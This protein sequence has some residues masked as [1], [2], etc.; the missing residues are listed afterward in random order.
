MTHSNEC[1]IWE[2]HPAGDDGW[3]DC[4]C[5]V[6]NS[7]STHDP[8]CYMAEGKWDGGCQCPLIAKVRADER[9]RQDRDAFTDIR[10]DGLRMAMG[11]F[12]PCPNCAKRPCECKSAPCCGVPWNPRDF[13]S[14]KDCWWC[15][16]STQEM[17]A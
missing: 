12:D 7:Q 11:N 15:Q 1:M 8:L 4:T 16:R 9:A 6:F 3:H 5:Q 14:G 13:T 17:G 10:F 2:S